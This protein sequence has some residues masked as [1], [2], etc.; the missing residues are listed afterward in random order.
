MGQALLGPIQLDIDIQAQPIHS[1][2]PYKNNW[3]EKNEWL[4]SSLCFCSFPKF[5][6]RK[7]ALSSF[8]WTS[9]WYLSIP[10]LKTLIPFQGTITLNASSSIFVFQNSH[11]FCVLIQRRRWKRTAIELNGRFEPK[12][13]HEISGLLMQS[14]SE[15]L[16][17]FFNWLSNFCDS[18]VFKIADFFLGGK[19]LGHFHIRIIST[20]FRVKRM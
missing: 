14:Y 9:T 11:F 13:R 6:N 12:Y 7:I 8:P 3:R 10:H 19:R 5:R 4:L 1:F 2:A 16:L 15:V 20:A 18:V 17:I